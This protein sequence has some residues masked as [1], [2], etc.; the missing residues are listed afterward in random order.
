MNYCEKNISRV[1]FLQSVAK[2]TNIQNN[3]NGYE[4][5]HCGVHGAQLYD[6]AYIN[7]VLQMALFV[8]AFV[9]VAFFFIYN[10]YSTVLL[11]GVVRR[12]FVE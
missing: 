11:S 9:V 12:W 10:I 1:A 4:E 7:E 5:D 3:V 6:C 8:L 2:T